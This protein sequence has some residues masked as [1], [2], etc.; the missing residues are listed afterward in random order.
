MTGAPI[1]EAG[2]TGGVAPWLSWC[3]GDGRT[4]VPEVLGGPAP[5]P[6]PEGVRLMAVLEVRLKA[7]DEAAIWDAGN[8][9]PTVGDE[10]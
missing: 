1:A 8:P 9:E 7:G 6:L 4:G 3:C 5:S 10:A 2:F